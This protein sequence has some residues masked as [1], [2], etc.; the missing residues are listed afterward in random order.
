MVFGMAPAVTRSIAALSMQGVRI[1]SAR[2]AQVMRIR[3]DEKPKFWRELLIASRAADADE[4]VA[5]KHHAERRLLSML[6]RA[7]QT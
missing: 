6:R 3:W 5:L 4:F 2:C 1:I 7:H